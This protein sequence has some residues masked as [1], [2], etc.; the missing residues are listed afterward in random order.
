LT[1]LDLSDNRLT[2]VPD[3]IA[4]LTALTK[5]H[6]GGNRLSTVPDWIGN[7]TALTELDL[8]DNRLTAVPDWIGSLTAL[9]ELDLSDNRLTA[10]P[11]WI[12]NL[13]ALTELDVGENQ[14]SRVTDA[15]GNL[16]AL[17]KLRLWDNRLN[18]V[19]D[20]IG[21]L[22][23]LTELDLS[24]NPLTAV[25][26]AIAN[27]TALTDLGLSDIGLVAVPEVI[28]NLTSLTAL[29][30]SDNQLTAMPDWI[31][32]LTALTELD[33]WGN[34]FVAVPEVIANLTSLT[35]LDLSGNRLNTVPDWIGN[36]TALTELHLGRNR[37]NTVPDRIAN[38]TALTKLHLGGN[39]LTVVPDWIG[40]LTALTRLDVGG[41]QLT[42]VPDSIAALAALTELHVGGNQLTVVP[43]WIG[44][45]TALTELHIGGSHLTTVPDWI[46]NLTALTGLDLGGN[47]L[48]AVPDWIGNLTALTRLDLGGNQLTAVPDWIGNLTALTELNLAGTQL[49]TVPD[50]IGNLTSLTDLG[51]ARNQL[52]VVPDWIGNL[53]ALTDLDLSGNQLTTLADSIAN[54]TALTRLDVGGNQLSTV[55]DSIA[56][57][58]ALTKLWL[59]DNQLTTVP[60]W[61]GD[62]ALL[63]EL[64]LWSNQLSTVPDSIANLTALTKLHLGDNRLSTVPDWIGD[65][66][67]LTELDIW[68]NQL[69]TVP[70][71]I[72]DLTALTEL[73]LGDNRLTAVPD[74]IGDLTALTELHLWSNQLSTVPDS[75]ANLTALT[76][77]DLW[78]NRLS[79][80][81]D[82]IANLTALA[83]LDLARN[84]LNAL[85]R[86][87]GTLPRLTQ[88]SVGANRLAP[89]VEAAAEESTDELLRLLRL[90]HQEGV[91]LAEA[92]LILV[93]E[94]T[95]GKSSLLASLRG[96]PWVELRGQ[97]HGLEIKKVEVEYHGKPITLNGWDFG[98]QKEYRPTHQLFFTAPAIYLVVWKPREGPE[99]GMVEHWLATIQHR[100]G[101]DAR[102][103]VVATHG[104]SPSRVASIDE[105]RLRER[106]GDLI[107]DFHEVDSKDPNTLVGLR[108]AIAATADQVRHVRRWYPASWL[109]TRGG[110]D[111]SGQHSLSYE[112]YLEIT[113]Q[114]GLTD[115]A[116]RS[117]AINSHAL[118]HWIHYADEPTLAEIV[119]LKPDWLS[120][121]IAAVLEDGQAS[122]SGGLVPHRRFGEI[123]SSPTTARQTY[124]PGMQ[125]V[126]LRLME[127]FELTYRVPEFSAGEPVSLVGQ[128]VPSDRPDLTT[129]WDAFRPEGPEGV[130]VCQ[131]V[132]RSTDRVVEPEGLIYRLIVRL[133]RQSIDPANL[134]GGAHWRGGLLS[135][136]RYGARALL[137]LTADGVRVQVR[138]LDPHQ[139]LRQVA[140][141]VRD[142]VE[143]FWE[144]LRTRALVPCTHPCGLGTPG[145]GLFDIDKLIEARDVHRRADF[146]CNASGCPTWPAIDSLLGPGAGGSATGDQLEI[147]GRGVAEVQA[148]LEE[149]AAAQ[150]GGTQRVLARI[151]D[152]D[153]NLKAR[154]DRTDAELTRIMRSLSDE[155]ADGP[156]LFSLAPAD[157]TRLRPGWTTRRMRLTLYCEHS[158]W[159][160]HALD[161][162][163]PRAGI[164]MLDIPRD[165]WVKAVP[166]LKVTSTLLKP[167]LGIGLA[168]A[169]LDLSDSQWA[170]VKEQLNLGK[171]TLNAAASAA[172]SADASGDWEGD[173][174]D[175]TVDGI[176]EAEGSV[177][178]NLHTML[179][180]KDPGYADLRRVP[181]Q[182]G[183]WL[184]IHPKFLSIYQP[185]LPVIPT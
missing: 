72:G 135:Q 157:R 119:I 42:V 151:E 180:D 113:A 147:I 13:T 78:G 91:E 181:D 107:V 37:L 105:T 34:R 26:D 182:Q 57:L 84:Q 41:N 170:A 65:L 165:W 75:I 87:L 162:D 103:H 96:D 174:P 53:T 10:V 74:S 18:T 159:P 167:F 142:C 168:A 120:V 137:T 154:L 82:W 64:Y 36:L 86:S 80:V 40:S 175:A 139:Y 39:R 20:W 145:R 115:T 161:P 23:A 11:D 21:N 45:L 176:I 15:I 58:T 71:S 124:A 89:E 111:K 172:G 130:I 177:L 90:I 149:V 50:W 55:P 148:R 141:D 108:A 29:D 169:E 38:L 30:L 156:R 131:V 158:R 164:Y 43:D 155:A 33:L 112:R 179:K 101:S 95:V 14:L 150:V 5:L 109:Q 47:Q 59:G 68:G 44:S 116:A 49:T 60:N 9:T 185:P 132:E 146:P 32:N 73:H 136:S 17:T 163:R 77:L 94:G 143:G 52:I 114:N 66:T 51:L 166:L 93:G 62:L 27:L 97:T 88:L 81:P 118:G 138:G 63:T 123:W 171:E 56:N 54:L 28:A 6:L 83:K 126:L 100:A 31:G 48:T 152:L 3:R 99:L 79:T 117:L 70:D 19:P 173:R 129:V 61:I 16:T 134:T 153:D 76:E 98:G 183:R 102:V 69:S 106:F 184:W 67:A 92:K 104:G 85:P 24:N 128:L 4:N 121:A 178:R 8:S 46:A 140:E 122:S 12:G 25:P 110:L 160:V 22:T 1:E 35:A 133:H 125:R 127:R 7:L 2:A 144:G